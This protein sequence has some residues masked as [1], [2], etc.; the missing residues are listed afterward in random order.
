MGRGKRQRHVLEAQVL[1]LL[2]VEFSSAI[3][4]H[5]GALWGLANGTQQSCDI[6]SSGCGGIRVTLQCATVVQ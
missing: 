1:D 2:V 4:L 6:V 3:G 5:D